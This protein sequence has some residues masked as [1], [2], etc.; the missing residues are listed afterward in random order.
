MIQGDSGGG[1]FTTLGSNPGRLIGVHSVR[2][3]GG[4]CDGRVG[5]KGVAVSATFHGQWIESVVLRDIRCQS[6][7]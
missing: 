3:D 1:Y 6:H 4:G 5:Y 7:R 2:K